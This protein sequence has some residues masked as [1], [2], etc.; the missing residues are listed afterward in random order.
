MH[1]SF[2]LT[3]LGGSLGKMVMVMVIAEAEKRPWKK[4]TSHEHENERG[5]SD[6]PDQIRLRSSCRCYDSPDS[7]FC[8]HSQPPLVVQAD[9][10]PDCRRPVSSYRLRSADPLPSSQSLALD[11]HASSPQRPT[12]L[13]LM[14]RKAPGCPRCGQCG[15]QIG[16]LWESL[17]QSRLGR[18]CCG[19]G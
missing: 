1:V 16:P 17:R 9:Y 11:R 7:D 14:Q 15:D 3:V 4:M 12:L 19:L 6:L 18:P 13:A 10:Q 2:Y 8:T 5:M